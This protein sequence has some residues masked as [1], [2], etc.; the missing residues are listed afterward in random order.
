MLAF[1]KFLIESLDIDKL[2]H[3]EHAEDHI[4]HGGDEGVAH[5]ANNLDDLHNMLTGGKSKSKITTKYDGC[6]SGDTVLIT[7]CGPMTIKDLCES[8]SLC[9]NTYVL[10]MIDEDICFVNVMDKLT[11]KS[12][13]QW[14]NVV[15]ENNQSIKL[16]SDHKVMLTDK[17]W[18]EA[19]NLQLG[20]D[21]LSI[22][23][24]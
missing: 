21:V 10:G 3:L 13:K 24:S 9:S 14:V 2:K 12:S 4:I 22:D 1:S 16:T 11:T 23:I 5:A 15:F 19:G 20:D 8:W 7:T 6:V 18:R 17:T